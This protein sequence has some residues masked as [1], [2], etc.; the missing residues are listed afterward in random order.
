MTEFR[1][2]LFRSMTSWA[3]LPLAIVNGSGV[4]TVTLLIALWVLTLTPASAMLVRVARVL[5]AWALISCLPSLVTVLY[6]LT[7]DHESD[8]GSAYLWSSGLEAAAV[9]VVC[10]ACLAATSRA[11][12]PETRESPEVIPIRR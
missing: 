8:F 6:E 1:R 7:A 4:N 9:L 11:R 2:V 10:I 12:P 5:T 3:S